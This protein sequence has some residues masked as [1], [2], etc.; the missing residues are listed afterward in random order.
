MPSV[1]THDITLSDYDGGNL[2]G[3]MLKR[4]R[5]GLRDFQ[6]RD[7]ETIP[8]RTLTTDELTQAAF[9]AQLELVWFEEDWQLGIGGDIHRLDPKKVATAIKMDFT[10]KGIAQPA[11]ESRVSTLSANPDEFYPSGFALAS[12]DT[13]PGNAGILQ[14]LWA[15]IGSYTFYGGD[16]NWTR[17]T[18]PQNFNIYY[19]NGVQFNERVL[20]PG[21]NAG[22]DVADAPFP[23]IYKDPTSANWVASTL[24]A[25][26][27]KFLSK[28]RDNGNQ[29]V[30]WGA[31]HIFDTGFTLSGDHDASDTTLT[32]SAN[33]TATISVGDILM[34]GAGG[35]Q[36]LLLVTATSSSDP[37]LTVVRQYGSASVDPSGGEKIYLYQPHVIKSSTSPENSSGSWSSAVAI[38][39]ANQPI[40]GLVVDQD[41]NEIF[42]AKTD[43]LWSYGYD[44]FERTTERNLT[45]EFRQ[46]QH[47]GNFLGAYSWNRHILLPLGAGGMLD[48]NPDTRA[49]RDVS[50]RSKAPNTTAYHGVVLA[51]HGDSQNLFM[52]LKDN[53]AE[54]IYLLQGELLSF[55]GVE[56]FRWSPIYEATATTAI[57]D[58]QTGLMV[59]SALDD[60]RRVWWGFTDTGASETPRFY[61]FGSINDDQTDGFTNDTDPEW[62]TTKYDG[63]LPR[64]PKRVSRIEIGSLNL[65]AGGRQIAFDYRVDEENFITGDAFNI[66][67]VQEII[68][69]HGTTGKI[70]ELRFKPTQ[71]SIGTTNPV[72]NY[73][74]ITLQIRPDPTKVYP[75][76]VVLEDDQLML[77]GGTESRT[78]RNLSQLREWNAIPADVTLT[79]P[80]G[81]SKAV[82][83]LPG[84][85]KEKQLSHEFGRRP[86]TEVSFLLAEVA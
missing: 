5:R 79:T 37:H 65:G 57:T 3:F 66:S 80:D 2:M 30:L 16:D 78:R 58:N 29:E 86:G 59:E 85:M 34:M 31:H 10:Q 27:F 54:K 28:A 67:P 69:D 47:S 84:T 63:N 18:E 38:G 56:D 14:E 42:V 35:S 75:I 62:V 32:L 13:D 46:Q 50:F 73:F 7:A 19:G 17:G 64:V 33:P 82:I 83:F 9:P 8:P 43:G 60:H 20:A 4:N 6:V 49:I 76:I 22:T 68:L 1:K 39:R 70:I 52:L 44:Q 51:L 61:P 21:H 23:Y 55:D 81:E 48:F 71:T 25:G 45:I 53:T 11:R 40:T 72:M 12:P 15:F 41:T 26:R 74:R 36:E 77:N 24:T